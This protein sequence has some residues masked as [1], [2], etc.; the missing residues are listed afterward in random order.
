MSWKSAKSFPYITIYLPIYQW[1]TRQSLIVYTCTRCIVVSICHGPCTWCTVHCVCIARQSLTDRYI[2]I[3]GIDIADFHD[4]GNLERSL[5]KIGR[6]FDYLFENKC[7]ITLHYLGHPDSIILIKCV[8]WSVYR[9]QSGQYF[10]HLALRLER[11]C[12]WNINILFVGHKMLTLT[13][14]T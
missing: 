13:S 6:A 12:L 1:D 14:A 7:Y 8:I 5:A 4:I 9:E 2:V 11:N 10:S 3:E